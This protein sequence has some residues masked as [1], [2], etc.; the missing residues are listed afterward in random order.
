[1]PEPTTTQAV[2]VAATLPEVPV[3]VTTYAPLV[4]EDELVAVSVDVNAALLIVTE[5][6]ERLHVG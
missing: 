5:V 6:G 2:V 4:G 3:T 1:V